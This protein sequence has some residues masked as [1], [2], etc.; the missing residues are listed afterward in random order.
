MLIFLQLFAILACCRLCGWLVRRFLRQPQV[1]GEMMA[2]VLLGPSLFG[3][4]APGAQEW[5]FPEASQPILSNVAQL[6]IGVYMFLVG[7]EFRTDDFRARGI[8]AV[9]I[10]AA[11]ILVPFVLA[12]GG[13]PWLLQFPGLFGPQVSRF[14]AT[15]F[16]GSAIAIT[17][18]PVLARILQERGL[19][20]TSLATLSLSAAAIGDAVAWCVLAMVLASFR[21]SNSIAILAIFGGMALSA[22][23]ILLGPRLL[24][25]LGR[26]AEREA[27]AGEPLSP[28]LLAAALMAFAF[29]AFVSDAIGL[30]TVF[31]AFLVGTAMPRGVFARRIRAVLEPLTL[32]L[33]LPVF[34]AYSGLHTQ[35]QAVNTPALLGITLAI[36]G[37]SVLGKFVACWAAARAC[38][39]RHGPALGIGALMNARG[40]TELVIINIGLSAGIIEAPLFSMLVL[41]AIVTTLMASPLFELVYGRAARAR[42]ELPPL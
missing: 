32:V 10:C 35:L 37:A 23:V 4:L 34:F 19:A 29:A 30:H 24:A 42:G 39:E 41:M 27:A 33:L 14:D 28:G 36:L 5:L 8:T 26:R 11:G 9:A 22:A 15:L 3:A 16:L 18:L 38:G 12:L 17:A 40:L 1:I 20:H 13:T 21:S 25:P 6:G 2:G 7:L 31:G